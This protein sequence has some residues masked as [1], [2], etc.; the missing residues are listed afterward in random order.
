VVIQRI[1]PKVIT[2]EPMPIGWYNVFCP[3]GGDLNI[4]TATMDFDN[5]EGT[6]YS[7]DHQLVQQ[8][9]YSL[10]PGEAGV[11]HAQVSNL[12][13][14]NKVTWD[15]MIDLTV[16][17]KSVTVNANKVALGGKHFVTGSTCG[18]RSIEWRF[19]RWKESPINPCGDS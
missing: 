10:Q 9:A 7:R 6:E 12:E 18:T 13:G 4:T 15:L 14:N 2:R 11:F 17:S 19:G 5:P 1:W 3:Q 16:G 8:F